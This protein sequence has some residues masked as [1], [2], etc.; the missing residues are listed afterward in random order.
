MNT[1]TFNS[2]E[3]ENDFNKIRV[4]SLGLSTRT[5]RAL[6]SAGIRTVGGIIRNNNNAE[7]P[8]IDGLGQR[9]LEE[10]RVAL[11]LTS[12]DFKD[13]VGNQNNEV[14]NVDDQKFR[15]KEEVNDLNKIRVESLGLSTRT[16][17][18]LSNAGIRTVGGIA[19]K[20]NAPLLLVKG[21]GQKGLEEIK[22]AVHFIL[23]RH[24]DRNGDKSNEVDITQ[25]V[26]VAEVGQDDDLSDLI[27]T[28]FLSD[29]NNFISK[30]SNYFNLTA[31]Q[32]KG[33]SRRKEIV[34]VRDLVIYFLRTYWSMSFP[35][36]GHLLDKDHTTVM[37]AYRKVKKSISSNL[38]FESLFGDFIKEAAGLKERKAAFLEQSVLREIKDRKEIKLKKLIERTRNT[39]EIPERNIK[40]LEQYRTGAT[41]QVISNSFSITRERVRQVVK[42]TI[43]DIADNEAVIT[44]VS[45]DFEGLIK[46]EE[47]R[48]AL[49]KQS[50]RK[51]KKES[52]KRLNRKEKLEKKFRY[53]WSRNYAFCKTCG[54]TSVPHFI[55]GLCENCG[56]K[57]IGGEAREKM[58]AEHENECNLCGISRAESRIKHG[59]DFSLSRADKSVLCMKCHRLKT[60]KKLGD[61]KRNKWRMFYK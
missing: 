53:E 44:G 14:R 52:V 39:R 48:R 29:Q 5:S 26:E 43:K 56:R 3:D 23:Q 49:I 54:T 15:L 11:L 17:N 38:E 37:F 36:I 61:I 57:S 27:K 20:D 1:L 47:E 4:D 25:S 41:L 13:E 31:D 42:K 18:A 21:L 59:R 55:N 19:K 30:F 35:S 12:Q 50:G 33:T 2:K 45:V 9:G 22:V 24:H 6:D 60:G 58:I 34:Y 51:G 40:I 32:V 16:V 8:F 28:H 7:L 10:I 46:K